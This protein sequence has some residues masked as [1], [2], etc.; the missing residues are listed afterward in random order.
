MEQKIKFT[1][2]WYINNIY[3]YISFCVSSSPYN[4][5]RFDMYRNDMFII[6]LQIIESSSWKDIFAR[7]IRVLF[8]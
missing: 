5:Y 4:I 8:Y 1:L 7:S 3:W 2:G 6:A